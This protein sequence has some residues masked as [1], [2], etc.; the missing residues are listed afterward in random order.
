[1]RRAEISGGDKQKNANKQMK[2]P[3]SKTELSSNDINEELNS[4]KI[5]TLPK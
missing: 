4:E 5:Q 2:S 3:Q 1:M